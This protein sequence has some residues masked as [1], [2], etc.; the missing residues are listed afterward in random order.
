MTIKVNGETKQV[1]DNLTVNQLFWELNLKSRGKIVI[2]N[3]E[4][5]HKDEWEKTQLSEGDEIEVLSMV[6][7]G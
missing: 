2:L 4:V 1:S 7:G 3:R 5:V 6:G